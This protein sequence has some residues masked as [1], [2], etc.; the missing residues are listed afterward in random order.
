MIRSIKT[1]FQANWFSIILTR[2]ANRRDDKT[3]PP[4]CCQAHR[5]TLNLKYDPS[6]IG[7]LIALSVKQS[8]LSLQR[9]CN[10]CF[11]HNAARIYKEKKPNPRSDS[12][13]WILKASIFQGKVYHFH[14][15]DSP[16]YHPLCA[17]WHVC[18]YPREKA[19]IYRKAWGRLP[20]CSFKVVLHQNQFSSEWFYY[21]SLPL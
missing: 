19:T 3:L 7:G 17:W 21:I 15:T 16:I 4:H 20:Q 13:L 2:R 11:P 14:R 10:S 5:I 1:A 9:C 6:S 12:C 18:K 8:V